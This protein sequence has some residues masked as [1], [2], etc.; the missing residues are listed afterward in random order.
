MKKWAIRWK[1]RE[2]A[3]TTC[4]N[5][6][7]L[8]V[9]AKAKIFCHCQ[10]LKKIKF[11]N[12]FSSELWRLIF[13]FMQARRTHLCKVKSLEETLSSSSNSTIVQSTYW[14]TWNRSVVEIFSLI[15][16]TCFMELRECI[17]MFEKNRTVEKLSWKT[18]GLL[19]KK[20]RKRE[21]EKGEKPAKYTTPCE[22]IFQNKT[23][24]PIR[25]STHM[26]KEVFCEID[27]IFHRTKIIPEYC[28]H[29]PR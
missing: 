13:M 11:Y 15:S 25:N 14:T 16:N 28:S 29:D 22:D 12:F 4:R 26:K 17:S 6:I 5:D 27:T 9:I 2:N 21:F 8:Q 3:G 24:S 19:S 1:N 23:S 20:K 7:K 10:K 18:F